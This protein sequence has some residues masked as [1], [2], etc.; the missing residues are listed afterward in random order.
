MARDRR[1]TPNIGVR[2]PVGSAVDP[3]AFVALYNHYAVGVLDTEKADSG[4]KAI[5]VLWMRYRSVGFRRI[6]A[7]G[8]PCDADLPQVLCDLLVAQPVDQHDVEAH[9]ALT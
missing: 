5:W 8:R 2:E 7:G 1:G 4:C 9:V 3:Q 6:G